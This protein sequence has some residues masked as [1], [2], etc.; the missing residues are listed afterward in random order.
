MK[1]ELV[2]EIG[3]LL[4]VFLL[5]GIILPHAVQIRDT[6]GNVYKCGVITKEVVK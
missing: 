1:Q 6:D 4:T 5:G 3:M 2:N